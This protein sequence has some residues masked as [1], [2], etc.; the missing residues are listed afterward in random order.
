MSVEIILN[1]FFKPWLFILYNFLGS[2][3]FLVNI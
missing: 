3:E 1:Y 2:A